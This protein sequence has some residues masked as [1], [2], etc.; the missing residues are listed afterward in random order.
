MG[1]NAVKLG[2]LFITENCCLVML[3]IFQGFLII[4]TLIAL[5]AGG[6]SIY[7]DGSFSFPNNA[8]VP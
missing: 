1:A 6:F 4:L 3:P 2:S 5:L 8:A 7:S